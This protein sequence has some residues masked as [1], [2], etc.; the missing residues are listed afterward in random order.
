M[1]AVWRSV[2]PYK[3]SR[4]EISEVPAMKLWPTAVPLDSASI[5]PLFLQLARL[6]TSDVRRG[7]LLPGTP[8][9][10]S[11]TLAQTLSVHRNTVLAAY[12]ELEAE[13]WIEALPRRGVFVS[14]ALP[15]LTPESFT[16]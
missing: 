16:R 7:R 4:Y 2:A 9:P 11:R 8:L 15:D 1:L 6:I 12:R 10:G 14:S 3:S 13:G 5:E